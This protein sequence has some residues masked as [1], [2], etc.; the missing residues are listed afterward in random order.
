MAAA[1]AGGDPVPGEPRSWVDVH[2]VTLFAARAS[3]GKP[4]PPGTSTWT[5]LDCGCVLQPQKHIE[6]GT[7]A[8]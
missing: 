4:W 8:R 5:G 2:S 7:M 3:A 6:A 1:A